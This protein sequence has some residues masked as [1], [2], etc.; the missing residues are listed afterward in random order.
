MTPETGAK[1]FFVP[2]GS[3]GSRHRLRYYPPVCTSVCMYSRALC[4]YIHKR[5]TIIMPGYFMGISVAKYGTPCHIVYM[6]HW[7]KT[8]ASMMAVYTCGQIVLA[9][10]C[11]PTL[12]KKNRRGESARDIF[13]L[14]RCQQPPSPPPPRPTQLSRTSL[15]RADCTLIVWGVHARPLV[16]GE[17]VR[18]EAEQHAT[19]QAT[20]TRDM[21][22]HEHAKH[23][24]IQNI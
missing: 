1:C 5:G 19:K 11:F 18:S 24:T 22:S 13:S 12:C 10:V 17:R 16:F 2:F 4:L 23:N 14:K 9:L 20:A 7:L 15:E 3:F 21:Q 6:R 8:P